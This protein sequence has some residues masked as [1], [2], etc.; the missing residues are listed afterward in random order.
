[1][2]VW[3][4]S[5]SCKPLIR[6]APSH[7]KAGITNK[8]SFYALIS[9]TNFTKE[10]IRARVRHC[11]PPNIPISVEKHWG[12]TQ[13]VRES[14]ESIC[15]NL[16][17]YMHERE[18]WSNILH[19]IPLKPMAAYKETNQRWYALWFCALGENMP[20]S[21]FTKKLLFLFQYHIL[22]IIIIFKVQIWNKSCHNILCQNEANY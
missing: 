21:Q 8:L 5:R 15:L 4:I 11:K 14:S 18:K 9:A 16:Y 22:L 2:C 17:L 3:Q 7:N 20:S 13:G 1:M 12:E 10:L 6:S 19:N